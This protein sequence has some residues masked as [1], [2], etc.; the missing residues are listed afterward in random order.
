MR[1]RESEKW[2]NRKSEKWKN[3]KSVKWMKIKRDKII[4]N[5]KKFWNL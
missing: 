4:N 3:R 1:N 5:L 2:R